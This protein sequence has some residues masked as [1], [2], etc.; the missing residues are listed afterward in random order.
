M[1]SSEKHTKSSYGGLRQMGRILDASSSVEDVLIFRLKR[2]GLWN[3]CDSLLSSGT[4]PNN[5][6]ME[7]LGKGEERHD[8]TIF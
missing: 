5:A 7:T 1:R 3:S 2:N 4:R 6:K 8:N